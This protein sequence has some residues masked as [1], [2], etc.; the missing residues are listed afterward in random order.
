[1]ESTNLHQ[2][3][4]WLKSADPSLTYKPLH[5]RDQTV[6]DFARPHSCI[7]CQQAVVNGEDFAEKPL[8]DR[9]EGR[10][11]RETTFSCEVGRSLEEAIQASKAGCA[12]YQWLLDTLV[13]NL[14]NLHPGDYISQISFGLEF[15]TDDDEISCGPLI[16]GSFEDGTKFRPASA[17]AF[18]RGS[19]SR[20]DVCAHEG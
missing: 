10:Y 3:L 7:Y 5:S 15:D 18:Q 8:I 13:D 20:L 11:F 16:N 4:E 9:G 17:S 6:V 14:K 1:M 2:S 19:W 12:L